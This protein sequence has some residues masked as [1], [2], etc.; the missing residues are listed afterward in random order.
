MLFLVGMDTCTIYNNIFVL[1]SRTSIGWMIPQIIFDVKKS[2]VNIDT[3][4]TH[5][6]LLNFLVR[7]I[8]PSRI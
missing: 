2:L 5:L 4:A 6:H 8:L 1:L 3:F 7:L